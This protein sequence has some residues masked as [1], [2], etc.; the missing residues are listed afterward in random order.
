MPQRERPR[1]AS[2]LASATEIVASLGIEEQ[3]IAISHECDYPAHV[4]DR[5]RVS[6]PRFDPHGMDSGA[7]DRAVRQAMLEHGSAYELD[8]EGL[9]RLAP[10]LILTQ[11]VCEVCA[12]PTLSVQETVAARNLAAQVLSLDAHTLEDILLSIDQVGRAAGVPERASVLVASLRRRLDHVRRSV[13]HRPRPRTLALE[14]LDPP[15]VPGHWVPEQ[16]EIAGGT[17]V[18]GEVA[19]PSTEVSWDALARLDPDVLLIMPCGY[20]LDDANADADRQADA[21]HRIAP[22][23]IAAGRAYALDGSSYF[24]RSGPRAIAGVELLATL[25]Q[26]GSLRVATEHAAATW[27]GPAG[28]VVAKS[29]SA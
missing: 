21:L 3:L 5:P 6:R 14:W 27:L 25:L 22:R 1:I 16:I 23:A 9:A 11:A 13:L 26:P 17:C 8:G 15:F 12:V 2:L 18:A 24:N 20:G 28:S 4:L 7:I 19:R 29:G 10:Q